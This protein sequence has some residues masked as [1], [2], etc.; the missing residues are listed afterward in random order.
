MKKVLSVKTFFGKQINRHCQ[1]ISSAETEFTYLKK[2]KIV[3]TVLETAQISLNVN[4]YNIKNG[5]SS[6]LL[7]VKFDNRLTFNEHVSDLCKK[8][9]HK[10]YALA[11]VAL[12]MSIAK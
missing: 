2:G 12:F 3:K 10:I 11:R 6:K 8:A 1:T 4:K 9:S 7:G 5:K